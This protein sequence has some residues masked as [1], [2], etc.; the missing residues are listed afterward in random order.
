[1]TFCV[2]TVRFNVDRGWSVCLSRAGRSGD[3]I[4]VKGENFPGATPASCDMDTEPFMGESVWGVALTTL[5]RLASSLKKEY[6]YT[7]TPLLRLQ[8]RL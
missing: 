3:R 5:S 7:Y 6:I 2:T 1:M 4:P 8:G